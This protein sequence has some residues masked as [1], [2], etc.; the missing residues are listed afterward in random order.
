MYPY[1]KEFLDGYTAWIVQQEDL[2]IDT[3]YYKKAL[4]AMLKKNEIERLEGLGLIVVEKVSEMM[5]WKEEDWVALVDE[6][7]E[8]E[9]VGT[10][11]E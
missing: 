6:V 10:G 4:A 8:V 2:G 1:S 11:D 5:D 9:V 7:D 3:G